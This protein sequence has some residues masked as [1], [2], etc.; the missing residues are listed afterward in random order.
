MLFVLE[1]KSPCNYVVFS[2]FHSR[3]TRVYCRL[4]S[5]EAVLMYPR[6][7][8]L[9]DAISRFCVSFGHLFVYTKS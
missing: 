4:P 1:V 6:E 9:F 2:N 5:M 3:R 8:D 7:N